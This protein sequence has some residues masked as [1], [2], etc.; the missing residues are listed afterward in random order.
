MLFFTRHIVHQY[1]ANNDSMILAGTNST[2]HRNLKPLERR[3]KT[4]LQKPEIT[5]IRDGT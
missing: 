2:N 5:K 1:H 3:A 4:S